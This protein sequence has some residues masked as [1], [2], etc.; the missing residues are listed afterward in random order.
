MLRIAI[1]L[2]A[3][4]F[5]ASAAAQNERMTMTAENLLGVC[6]TAHP[7][8]VGFCNGF[9]QAAHD[10]PATESYIPSACPPQGTTRTQLVELYVEQA[11]RLFAVQPQHRH[12]P[13]ILVARA[14]MARQYPCQ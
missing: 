8:S 6:T 11:E 1:A 9:V 4:G 5:N 14:I 12:N 2:A 7:D 13:A 3:I 10:F